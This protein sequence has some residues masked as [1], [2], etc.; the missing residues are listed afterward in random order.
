MVFLLEELILLLDLG[1]LG[2]GRRTCMVFHAL[3]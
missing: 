1:L 2:L 3:N